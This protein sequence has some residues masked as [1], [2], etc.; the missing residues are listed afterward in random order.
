MSRTLEGVIAILEAHGHAWRTE[1]GRAPPDLM[2]VRTRAGR[3]Q[4]SRGAWS[5]HLWSTIDYTAGSIGSQWSARELIALGP[6]RCVVTQRNSD[7]HI[8]PKVE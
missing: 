4:R 2:L 5:W 8:D 3:H 1:D 7:T 6:T